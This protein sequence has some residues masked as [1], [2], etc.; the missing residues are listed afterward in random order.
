MQA[1]PFHNPKRNEWSLQLADCK[2][3]AWGVSLI[4]LSEFVVGDNE[5]IKIGFK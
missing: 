3:G 5:G 1:W 2:A 4:I